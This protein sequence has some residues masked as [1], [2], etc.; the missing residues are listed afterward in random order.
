MSD[1]SGSIQEIRNQNAPVMC[2]I[3]EYENDPQWEKLTLTGNLDRDNKKD[4]TSI[5]YYNK[6]TGKIC[7][8]VDNLKSGGASD[9][10]SLEI[11][12]VTRVNDQ[13]VLLDGKKKVSTIQ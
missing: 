13:E 8:A 11:Q 7:M 12:V 5:A 1:T 10:H 6:Q 4:Y 9:K 2:E 3:P